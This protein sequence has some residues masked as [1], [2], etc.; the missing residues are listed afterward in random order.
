M[1]SSDTSTAAR[2]GSVQVNKLDQPAGI[3]IALANAQPRVVHQLNESISH[4]QNFHNLVTNIYLRPPC[5]LLV[6]SVLSG[7]GGHWR[8]TVL[9]W[10]IPKRS[11]GHFSCTGPSWLWTAPAGQKENTGNELRWHTAEH[12][13]A[14]NYCIGHM[15][16]VYFTE[17]RAWLMRAAAAFTTKYKQ[18]HVC[19]MYIQMPWLHSSVKHWT[20][21]EQPRAELLLS[22]GLLPW[23]QLFGILSA[24]TWSR[25]PA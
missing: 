11:L 12:S 2:P 18:Q 24:S 4:H 20:I 1:F 9:W 17:Q 19:W 8:W 16:R 7:P 25:S 15:R 22:W 6:G 14:C 23:R 10:S 5:L 3:W 13:N 21:P